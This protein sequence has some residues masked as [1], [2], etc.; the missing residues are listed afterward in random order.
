[1]K[2]KECE[3]GNPLPKSKH[4]RY[5]KRC[6]VCKSKKRTELTFKEAMAIFKIMYPPTRAIFL[7]K[8]RSDIIK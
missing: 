4:G 3:C 6:F 5:Y 8:K 7:R 2:N 1:M